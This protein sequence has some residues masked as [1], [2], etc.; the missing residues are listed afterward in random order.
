M[1]RDDVAP[2]LRDKRGRPVFVRTVRGLEDRSG[3]AFP[4]YAPVLA[5]DFVWTL[6]Y[7]AHIYGGHDPLRDEPD[8]G[9]FDPR[10]E[11]VD[12]AA[13][14][15]LP[16]LERRFRQ[17]L[18]Y[19]V[20]VDDGIEAAPT[21]YAR[22]PADRHFDWLIRYQL[23]GESML[24]IAKAEGID[25]RHISRRIHGTADLIGLK[26]RERSP[27]GPARNRGHPNSPCGGL[28]WCGA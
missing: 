18:E 3:R 17:T 21:W 12:D 14:R 19:M 22:L 27:A 23:M 25:R 2:L 15:M 26:L 5:I 4:D 7:P 1:H 6:K 10:S 8:F 20:G 28:R 9:V 24:G 11:S 16:E 13:A